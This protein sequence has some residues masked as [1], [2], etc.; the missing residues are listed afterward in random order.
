MDAELISF[1][2]LKVHVNGTS[3]VAVHHRSRQRRALSEKQPVKNDTLDTGVVKTS[4]PMQTLTNEAL[5]IRQAI[6]TTSNL[7]KLPCHGF[8][9]ARAS[10]NTS[11]QPQN[12]K[13]DPVK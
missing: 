5:R 10:N 9:S 12:V 1:T 11:T 6:E 13:A 8:A 3:V 4:A 2:T 7:Q